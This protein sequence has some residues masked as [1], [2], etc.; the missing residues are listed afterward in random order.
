VIVDGGWKSCGIAA[1]IGARVGETMFAYLKAPF[2]RVTLP[3]I[4]APASRTL[5]QAYYPTAQTIGRAIRQVCQYPGGP[6]GGG[7]MHPS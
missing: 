4:P 1:E 7:E 6:P 2:Q 3:D 5:Q